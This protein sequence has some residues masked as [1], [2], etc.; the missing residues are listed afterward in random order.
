MKGTIHQSTD[1]IKVVVVFKCPSDMGFE[2]T[3]GNIT[4]TVST[5]LYSTWNRR[6]RNGPAI[7]TLTHSLDWSLSKR[8]KTAMNSSGRFLWCLSLPPRKHVPCEKAPFQTENNLPT[9][10]FQ[11]ISW[12]SL[13]VSPEKKWSWKLTMTSSYQFFVPVLI[14]ALAEAFPHQDP[15]SPRKQHQ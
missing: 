6:T 11:G 9:I 1:N 14:L 7:E 3:N 10:N 4:S 8:W 12:S 13:G 15:E 5:T 2:K